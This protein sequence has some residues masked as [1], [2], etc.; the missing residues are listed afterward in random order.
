MSEATASTPAAFLTTT[1]LSSPRRLAGRTVQPVGLG[2]M[3]LNHGYSNFLS[4]E[5]AVALVRTALD[6]GVDHFDTATL[7]DA[8]HNEEVVGRA[9]GAHRQEVFL[10]SKGGLTA[11]PDGGI[12]GRPETL[13]RQVEGSLRRLGTDVIDLYYLHRLDPGVPVE[14]SAGALA[15]MVQAG[16]IGAYGLSEVS[17]A[18]LERAHAVHPVAA[19]QNEYSLWT[20]NPEWGLLDA[21]RRTGTVLVAFSPV[22]R[23]FLTGTLHEPASL[24]EGD[25]RH[26][27]PRFS[28]ENYPANLAL[29]APFAAEAVRLGTTP[30][31]L[32]IAWVLA[33][34]PDVVAIPGTT[35]AAHL[36]EDRAAE[37]VVLTADD[38]TRIDAIVNHATV[39]GHRYPEAQR[40]TIDT[41]DAPPA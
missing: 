2:C 19:V 25:M 24:P 21:C 4:D 9:L 35:S 1:D 30:A 29:L 37:R 5:D 16:K 17:A 18:T 13:R 23:A 27:M 32:A 40:P 39:R 28:A 3:N 6:T 20:R 7:Y 41:E 12:D 34:G 31:A 10:A 36:T 15:E 33:Q 11:G 22:A 8:G 26:R 14:E 38:I